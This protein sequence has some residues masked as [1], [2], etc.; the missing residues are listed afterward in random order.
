[1]QAKDLFFPDKI[2][3]SVEDFDLTEALQPNQILIGNL[4]RLIIPAPN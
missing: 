2:Q 4:F 1:M 3:V